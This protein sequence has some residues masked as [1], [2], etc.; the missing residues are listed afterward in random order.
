MMPLVAHESISAW[1]SRLCN[2]PLMLHPTHLAT[3]LAY[4]PDSG[5]GSNLGYEVVAGVAV[6]RICGILVQSLGGRDYGDWATAYDAIRLSFLAAL[7]DPDVKA[8]VFS[9]RSGGGE[10]SGCFD[11]ADTIYSARGIKP[12]LAIL[13]ESAY[14]AAYALASSCEQIAVPRTGGTGSVGVICA[15]V[16]MS[17]ALEKFGVDITLITFGARKAD[18]A[19]S[20]PLSDTALARFQADVDVMGELFVETVARN[21]GIAASKIRDTEAA[22][23]LGRAGVSIGLADAVMSPDTAFR[24]LLSSIS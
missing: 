23:F 22:T 17:K 8:I 2:R 16:D 5:T 19:E 21:R 15:H 20:A 14:S 13:C 4:S 12:T 10:V 7:A 6:I 11:L 24:A 1:G 18:G 3:A 9:V